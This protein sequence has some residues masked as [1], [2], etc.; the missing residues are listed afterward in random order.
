[1]SSPYFKDEAS[2]YAFY[3]NELDGETRMKKLNI[4]RYLC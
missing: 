3:L 2:E 1:M 4:T